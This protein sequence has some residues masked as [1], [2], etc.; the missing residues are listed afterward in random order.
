MQNS[1]MIIEENKKNA[2]AFYKMMAYEG[3]P[4]HDI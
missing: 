3:N 1:N 4:P 2:V